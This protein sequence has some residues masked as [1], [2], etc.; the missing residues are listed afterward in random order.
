MQIPS[1]FSYVKKT[2]S[3]I[4]NNL[5]SLNLD[6]EALFSIRLSIEE[7][8]INAIRHGNKCDQN[9]SVT[10][11]H[12]VNGHKLEISVR[13]EGKGFD[14]KI[15]PDPTVNK[16]IERKGGRGIFLIRHL[17]DKVEFNKAGNEIRMIK[18]LSPHE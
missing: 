15:L 4:L 6:Q 3:K 14:Y 2:S 5:S 1:N 12:S 8:I 17:M 13:D 10:I 18:Y 9:L 11:T 16:N 7:A